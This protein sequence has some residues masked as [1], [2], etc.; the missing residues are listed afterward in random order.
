MNFKSEEPWPSDHIGSRTHSP[1]LGITG[2]SLQRK[3]DVGKMLVYWFSS[4]WNGNKPYFKRDLNKF[5]IYLFKLKCE[6]S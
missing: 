1:D 6:V 2:D 4:V 5:Y 3:T